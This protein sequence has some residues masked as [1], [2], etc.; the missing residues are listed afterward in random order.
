[1]QSTIRAAQSDSLFYIYVLVKGKVAL[2]VWLDPGS[3]ATMDG[4]DTVPRLRKAGVL[5]GECLAP[6]DI[7]LNGCEGKQTS[8]L[9]VLKSLC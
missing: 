1:M 7:V 9:S 6:I 2:K 3:M 5:P 8:P 4:A